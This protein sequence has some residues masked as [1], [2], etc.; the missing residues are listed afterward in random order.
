YTESVETPW[1]VFPSNQDGSFEGND[2][3]IFVFSIQADIEK[4]GKASSF[5]CSENTQAIKN[6]QNIQSL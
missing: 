2:H 1:M 3:K 4:N 5:P 6:L